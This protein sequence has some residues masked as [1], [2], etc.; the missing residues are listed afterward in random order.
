MSTATRPSLS[1]K[2]LRVVLAPAFWLERAKG[3][4]RVGLVAL[5]ALV[6]V[7]V[8]LLP[9]RESSLNGLPDIGDPFD[10]DEFGEVAVPDDENAIVLY[11]QAAAA[12]GRAP[13][14]M[15]SDLA[16]FLRGK[17]SVPSPE[18][19]S[20]L[21]ENREALNLWRRGTERPRAL[22]V[23]PKDLAL[24]TPFPVVQD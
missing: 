12:L 8:G 15:W 4:K 21:D 3:R 14:P 5:Y 6:A 1:S 18:V 23:R 24:D 17:T 9:G 10:V 22:Y 19:L 13:E 11:R 20:Y 2:I 16:G 7:V